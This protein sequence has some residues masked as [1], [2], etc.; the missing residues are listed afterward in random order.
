MNRIGIIGYSGHAYVAIDIFEAMGKEVSAYFEPKEAVNNPYDLNYLGADTI[1]T[2]SESG[3]DLFI[4]IGDNQLRAKLY[5]AYNVFGFTNAIHPSSVISKNV[6][7]GNAVMISSNVSINALCKIGNGV[8]C[9]TGSVIEHECELGDF[10]HIAPGAVLCGNVKVG[11]GSF[12]GANTV[13]KQGVTIG[14]N[15]IVGAGTVV[16]KDV[17]DNQKIVG[18]PQREL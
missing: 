7:L 17:E 13:V 1:E 5:N 11:K 15:V 18:N 2:V 12:I 10:V 8:I 6:K 14:E 9:N 16:I 3:L 4:G